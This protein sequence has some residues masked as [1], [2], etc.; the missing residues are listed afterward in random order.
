VDL[1]CVGVVLLE[2]ED[3]ADVGLPPAVD[4]L[5]GITDDKEIAVPLR[6]R[7]NQ[8]VLHPV[9]VL[10]LIDQD[11][12]EPLL[13]ALQQVRRRFEQI[14]RLRQQIVEIERVGAAQEAFVRLVSPR[15]DLLVVRGGQTARLIRRHQLA[16]RGGD[17]AQHAPRLIDLGVD[18]ERGERRFDDVSLVGR[19]VDRKLGQN[20]QSVGHD[21]RVFPQQPRPE[22]VKRPH[23]HPVERPPLP[24]PLDT[25]PHLARGLV[26]ECH[27]QDTV[28]W[29]VQ[30]FHE[31]GDAMGEHARLSRP[32]TGHDQDRPLGSKHRLPLLLV[33]PGKEFVFG[34]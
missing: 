11:V 13:V 20:P 24:Q 1:P 5:I 21:P 2:I 30:L 7:R 16:L 31:P 33:Q 12:L 19:V 3:V 32:R 6:Q 8:H 18:A 34:G 23:R 22:R 26:G 15:H 10:V 17:A 25:G 27:R 28:A 9:G 14:D 29:D 4:R